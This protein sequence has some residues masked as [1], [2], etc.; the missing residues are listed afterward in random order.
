M[1]EQAQMTKAIKHVNRHKTHGK[2]TFIRPSQKTSVK[3]GRH[4][5]KDT[6]TKKIAKAVAAIPVGLDG[7][8]VDE[9]T[10]LDV[11]PFDEASFDDGEGQVDDGGRV[12]EREYD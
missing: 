11:E 4:Q 7:Q 3:L 10:D 6:P 5:E 9:T 8:I 1:A 12:E 2:K